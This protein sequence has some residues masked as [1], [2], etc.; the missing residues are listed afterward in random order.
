[1]SCS[2]RQVTIPFGILTGL[3]DLKQLNYYFHNYRAKLADYRGCYSSF[4]FRLNI[5]SEPYIREIT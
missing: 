4:K 3:L 5:V 2:H 1:M